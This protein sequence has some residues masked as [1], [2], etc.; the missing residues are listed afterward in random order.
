MLLR[1]NPSSDTGQVSLQALTVEE[2]LEDPEYQFLLFF[3]LLS[4][5]GMKHWTTGAKI[6]YN[7][8]SL[9]GHTSY[10]VV[11]L[12]YCKIFFILTPKGEGPIYSNNAD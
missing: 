7:K 4:L 1:D 2:R 3:C 11:G 5:V 8:G 10:F 6:S 12:S 9:L